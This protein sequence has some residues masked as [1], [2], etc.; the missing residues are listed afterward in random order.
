MTSSD[1]ANWTLISYASNIALNKSVG[2]NYYNRSRA[3]NPAACGIWAGEFWEVLVD[4]Y[5]EE[6]GRSDLVPQMHVREGQEG[7]MYEVVLVYVP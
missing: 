5:T 4:L 1:D 3:C 2:G 7:Y 6:E